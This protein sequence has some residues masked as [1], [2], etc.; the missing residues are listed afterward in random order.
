MMPPPDRA[1]DVTCCMLTSEF[2]VYGTAAGG[3]V[4][5]VLGAGVA[6]AETRHSVALR[7]VAPNPTAT[8]IGFIDAAGDAFVYNPVADDVHAVSAGA[9]TD[10]FVWDSADHG[11]FVLGTHDTLVTCMYS[12]ASADGT[13]VAVVAS[14]RRSADVLPLFMRSGQLTMA[15]SGAA[16]TQMLA[17]HD[18]L[19]GGDPR[20]RFTQLL[21][22]NRLRGAFGCRARKAHVL[23]ALRRCL[24]RCASTASRR[25]VGAAWPGGVGRA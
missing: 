24:G 16:R 8:R 12:T 14:S 9:P 11:V 21:A 22:L 2:L 25:R 17:S 4:Q 18:T 10:A 3:L 13:T 20:K 5:I 23:M 15:A 6:A 7:V 19:A 1:G